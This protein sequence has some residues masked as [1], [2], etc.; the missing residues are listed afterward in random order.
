MRSA[1]T[2]CLLRRGNSEYN[3]HCCI[4][5]S[6]SRLNSSCKALILMVLRLTDR[7]A[8]GDDAPHA[9]EVG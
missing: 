4:Q 5:E 1:R 7:Y 6:R 3:W 2:L 9:G 8:F